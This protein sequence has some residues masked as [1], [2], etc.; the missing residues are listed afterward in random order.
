M[1]EKS[2][3]I[4]ARGT[5]ANE[6]ETAHAGNV[7][8]R[9]NEDSFVK[10]IRALEARNGELT[11][12]VDT[13]CRELTI[14]A[15]AKQGKQEVNATLVRVRGLST[16]MQGEYQT[17]KAKIASLERHLSESAR[18]RERLH[19]SLPLEKSRS[20]A[21]ECLL[22]NLCHRVMKHSANVSTTQR[23]L[24]RGVNRNLEN[25]LSALFERVRAETQI[26]RVNMDSDLD[27][28][29]T[30]LEQEAQSNASLV[31]EGLQQIRS[32]GT[33]QLI[34]RVGICQVPSISNHLVPV[35][36]GTA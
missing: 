2:A 31:G 11:T 3:A 29:S 18:E 21:A 35:S 9:K 13:T 7:K 25:Y 1:K 26:L 24:V 17:S 4:A 12:D 19:E 8:L 14:M 22:L 10:K 6:K 27:A 34:T 33:S 23:F 5:A 15:V 36:S 28:A 16:G 30:T 32:S 20:K